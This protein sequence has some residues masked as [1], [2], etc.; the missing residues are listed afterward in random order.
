MATPAT[1]IGIVEQKDADTAQREIREV[2][3]GVYAF[4]GAVLTDA[5]S[6]LSDANA[7]GER[8]LTDVV[9]IAPAT[10]VASAR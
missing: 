2:N 3:S 10:V 7:A 9:G 4:D 6:R 8:Y 5:L 1:L